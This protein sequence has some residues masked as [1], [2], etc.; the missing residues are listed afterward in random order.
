MTYGVGECLRARGATKLNDRRPAID[1]KTNVEDKLTHLI[2]VG[3]E[4]LHDANHREQ[5]RQ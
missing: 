1:R 5:L 3:H 2:V 4:E